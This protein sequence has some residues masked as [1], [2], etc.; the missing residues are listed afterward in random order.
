MLSPAFQKIIY[1]HKKSELETA[2]ERKFFHAEAN[3]ARPDRTS[4]LARL[5]Q[6]LPQPVSQRAAVEPVDPCADPC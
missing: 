2:I 5:A 3:P 6:K 4:W 1:D